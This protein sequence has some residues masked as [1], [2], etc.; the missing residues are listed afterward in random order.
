MK[1]AAM[2]GRRRTGAGGNL[3]LSFASVLLMPS[4]PSQV[5]RF[6]AL[7]TT[8]STPSST[9]TISYIRLRSTPAAVEQ[10]NVNGKRDG[11]GREE[12]LQI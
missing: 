9:L 12:K 6:L 4:S 3:T 8:T 7:R 2:R 1:V 5:Y 11:G 10:E